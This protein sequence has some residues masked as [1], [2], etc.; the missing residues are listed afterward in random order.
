MNAVHESRIIPH[1]GGHGAEQVA[2]A[3][4]V[5]D[6]HVEV[7]H[8]HDPA[9]GAYALA[10]TAELPRF[11]ISLHYSDAVLGVKRDPGHLIKAHYV[12]LADEAALTGG[13]V[14]EHPG[15]AGLAAADE[16]G[17]GTHLLVKVTLAC[18]TRPQ[19]YSVVVA[20]HERH[21]PQEQDVLGAGGEAAWLETDAPQE[22]LLPL[23]RGELLAARGQVV[24]DSALG[25]L[26][27]AQGPDAERPARLFLR[28][29]RVVL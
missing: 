3:L 4:L 11:H 29:G 13:V 15:D 14:D 9:V 12:V 8:H 5:F 7:P 19:F 1:L 27:R 22:E 20:L 28:D 21:H 6:V 10:A 2:D 17:V 26:D 25:K 23:V 16:V 24:Q 18:A